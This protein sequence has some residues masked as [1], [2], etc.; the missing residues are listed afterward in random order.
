VP[1]L[2]EGIRRFDYSD[3]QALLEHLS[4]YVEEALRRFL[5]EGDNREF[6]H[7]LRVE[8]PSVDKRRGFVLVLDHNQHRDERDYRKTVEEALTGSGYEIVYPLS[9]VGQRALTARVPLRYK[10]LELLC[11]IENA[12][13]VLCRTEALEDDPIACQSFIGLGIAIGVEHPNVLLTALS[14]DPAGADLQIP[15][16][17]QGVMVHRYDHL[18]QL[19][20]ILGTIQA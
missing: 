3:Y 4:R 9:T 7:F 16:D 13:W 17:L 2:L 8:K 18:G 5:L 14:R 10:L 15:A 20:E 12:D 19:R 6:I 1:P 11:L